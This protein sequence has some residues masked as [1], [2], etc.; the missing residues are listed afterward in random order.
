MKTPTATQKLILIAIDHLDLLPKEDHPELLDAAADA[1]PGDIGTCCRA[2]AAAMRQLS[3]QQ[4][5]LQI[6]IKD[7]AR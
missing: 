1:L 5:S 3:E 2:T 6:L 4:M 7:V